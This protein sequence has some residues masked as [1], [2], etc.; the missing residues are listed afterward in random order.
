MKRLDKKLSR[1]KK[2]WSWVDE[3]FVQ[4]NAI[5]SILFDSALN[6]NIQLGS[7]RNATS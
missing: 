5:L 2:L 4:T 1:A 7:T 3:N 6:V